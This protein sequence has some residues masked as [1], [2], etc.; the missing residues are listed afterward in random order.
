MQ[1]IIFDIDGTLLDSFDTD[2]EMFTHSIRHVLGDVRIREKW[3]MYEHVTDNGI[4]A[5]IA[6]DNG[7]TMTPAIARAI[8]DDH[9]A[10]L[11]HHVETRGPFREIPG[12][13]NYVSG[14]MQRSDV[15]IAYATGAWRTSALL[16]L[17]SAGF[18]LQGI[19]LATSDDHHERAYIM[20]HALSQLPQPVK[21]ITYYGDGEWDRTATSHLGWNFVPVGAKLGGLTRFGQ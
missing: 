18:P 6:Q 19:P 14:L 1:A 7:L 15:C 20:R 17:T 8:E 9:L 4:L 10:R 3:G 16:K 21:S 12:A 13:R 5:G 2:A 11:T